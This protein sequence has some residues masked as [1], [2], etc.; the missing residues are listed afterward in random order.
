MN[1]QEII[2]SVK[3]LDKKILTIVRNGLKGSLIFCLIAIFVLVTYNTIGEPNAYYIGISLLKSGL[4]FVVGF[5]ICGVAF[6]K[7]I[8]E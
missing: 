7:I 8:S 3:Q 6:N 1:F 2:K 5:L 4:F